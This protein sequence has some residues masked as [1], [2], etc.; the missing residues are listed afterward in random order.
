MTCEL[1]AEFT[2]ALY[3]QSLPG[4]EQIYAALAGARVAVALMDGELRYVWGFN[5]YDAQGREPVAGSTDRDLYG[6][7]GA[8][9]TAIKARALALGRPER[10][11]LLLPSAGGWRR[12][13]LT[14]TPHLSGGVVSGLFCILAERG[15]L[16]VDELRAPCP[17]RP[18]E[19]AETAARLER[20][21]DERRRAEEQLATL[22]GDLQRSRDLLRTLF[23]GL[24]DG[25]L[26]VD[27]AGTIL[28]VNQP[29]AA[30]LG[31][32]DTALLGRH[33]GA[34][35]SAAEE[36]GVRELI[37]ASLTD[38][39]ARLERLRLARADGT[40]QILDLHTLPLANNGR[41][42]EQLIV[43]ARDVSE[44]VKLEAQMIAAERFTANQH[45]AAAVAH[46]VNTPLQAIESCLH[47]AGKLENS[48][49]RGRYLRL[50]REEIQR[51]GHILRQLL[52]LYKP[53]RG[54][55][56][57]IA[58]NDLVERALLLV[59]SSLAHQRIAVE[60]ELA[61][62]LPPFA[63]R[64]DELTQVLLN[65][66]FNAM[67]AMPRGG[68]LTVCTAYEVRSGQGPLLKLTVSDS[69]PGIDPGIIDRIFEPFFTTKDNGSGLGLAVCQRIVGAH[70]GLLEA[71]SK[72]GGGASFAVT[73]RVAQLGGAPGER[74]L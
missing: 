41:S 7:A 54:H 20:E 65:L 30:L 62:E 22:N 6:A 2:A 29:F 27:R 67:Q 24:D 28:A 16:A 61:P 49:Q 25:L 4:A 14:A 63:G 47:L 60:R 3:A 59:S 19:R 5:L 45:L 73:L 31:A 52:D 18:A 36:L 64:A 69:G 68:C 13:E 50:A 55:E 21:I 71:V 10:G 66:I 40:S 1:H 33:W 34:C 11:E 56:T 15:D 58:L 53:V 26:L 37:Q 32:P 42:P 38:G 48:E 51:V 57:M 17:A 43:H 35:C 12:Y 39:Q 23:D 70:G 9:L 8:E 72:P 74:S 44:R 46:E